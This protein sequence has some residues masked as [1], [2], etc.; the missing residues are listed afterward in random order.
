MY[1]GPPLSNPECPT[2]AHPRVWNVA[3]GE[4]EV[5]LMGHSA[6]VLSVAVGPG[7]RTVVSGAQ[8]KTVR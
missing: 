3:T 6:G 8:D 7:G 4:C 1:T 5:R 2:L